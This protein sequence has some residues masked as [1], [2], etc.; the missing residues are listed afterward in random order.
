MAYSEFKRTIWS[1]HIQTELAQGCVLAEDCDYKF[2]GEAKRGNKVKILGVLRPTIGTYTGETIEAPQK[3]LEGATQYLNIDQADYFN[4]AVDDVDEAQSVEGLMPALMSESAKALAETCEKYIGSLA[5][6]EEATQVSTSTEVTDGE[7]AKELVDEAFVTLWE[8][9]VKVT[10]DVVINVT[11][12]FYNKFKNH[13]VELKTNN[14]ELIKKGV[15]GMYNNATVK[16]SNCLHNDGTDDYIMVRTKKAIAFAD[17]ID[18]TE[19]YR[20]EGLFSDAVKGLHVYGGKVVRPKELYV[21]KA[22]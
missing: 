2:E 10:D 15:V 3:D 8:N 20:P 5:A 18:E 11:P 14:D 17:Q 16:I 21:I 13:L 22:H 1:K 7:K 19:A 4:F 12:R 9:G 6:G